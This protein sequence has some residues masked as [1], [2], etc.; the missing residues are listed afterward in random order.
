MYISLVY[1]QA[2]VGSVE[3]QPAKRRDGA[4]WQVFAHNKEVP[5][6]TSFFISQPKFHSMASVKLSP[7]V[8]EIRGKVGGVVFQTSPSGQIVKINNFRGSNPTGSR[9]SDLDSIKGVN[10]WWGALSVA[11]RD[12]WAT[13]SLQFPTTN[14]YGDPLISTGFNFYMRNALLF[15]PGAGFDQVN[16]PTLVVD[17][18][19]YGTDTLVSTNQIRASWQRLSGAG[20][21]YMIVD[22]TPASRNTIMAAPNRWRRIYNGAINAG[23]SFVNVRPNY[24]SIWGLPVVAA[25]VFVRIRVY[26][27]F[28]CQLFGSSITRIVLAS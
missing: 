5:L 6:G 27:R 20:L 8:S 12:L 13:R 16:P 18:T 1:R 14:R 3:A 21:G 25:P 24:D 23:P 15:P 7:L 19:D 10:S 2:V 22:A 4:R 9:G 26:N 28:S 17:G 11:Q